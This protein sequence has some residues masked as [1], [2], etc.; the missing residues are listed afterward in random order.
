MYIHL[1]GTYVIQE[2][3]LIGIFNIDQKNSA[4]MSD[5][6]KRNPK[7]VISLAGEYPPVSCIV[8]KENIIISSISPGTLRKRKIKFIGN[9]VYTR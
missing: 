4:I 8:T 5:F 7:K 9:S 1:G 3:D 6:I 2:N